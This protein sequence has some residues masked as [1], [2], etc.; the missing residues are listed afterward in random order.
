MTNVYVKNGLRILLFVVLQIFVFKQ[1]NLGSAD[2]D[3]IHILVYPVSILLL[4]FDFNKLAVLF[5]AFFTGLFIDMFYDTP[6]LHAA[7]LVFMAFIR[8]FVLRGLAPDTGYKKATHPTAHSLG[9]LWY[10]QYSGILLFGFLFAYFSLSAFTWVYILDIL[11][12]TIMSF[13]VSFAI[14]VLHQILVVP[15]T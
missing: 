14:I 11:A 9:L 15:K 8:P 3:Y 4:P 12:N 1:I 6:G 7:A 2:F 5:I 10:L 13:I